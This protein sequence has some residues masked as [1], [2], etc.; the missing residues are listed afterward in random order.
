LS[1]K[2]VIFDEINEKI[3]RKAFEL[4]IGEELVEQQKLLS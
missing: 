3:S 1:A 4:R 2:V